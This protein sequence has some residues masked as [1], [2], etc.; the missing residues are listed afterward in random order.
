MAGLL[1]AKTGRHQQ[2][3]R[4]REGQ[5]TSLRDLEPLFSEIQRS[6]RE[7]RRNVI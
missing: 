2:E 1:L 4:R 6:T 5:E 7:R 3:R